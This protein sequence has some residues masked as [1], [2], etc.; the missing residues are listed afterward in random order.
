MRGFFISGP[1]KDGGRRVRK[2]G[3]KKKSTRVEISQRARFH[4][5]KKKLGKRSEKKTKF[6]GKL[7]RWPPNTKNRNR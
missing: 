6:E 2:S 7:G 3:G 1:E 4:G 5:E